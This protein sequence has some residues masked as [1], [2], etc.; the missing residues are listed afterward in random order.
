MLFFESQGNNIFSYLKKEKEIIL[1]NNL[2]N[3]LSINIKNDII[4][5][6]S[7][8]KKFNYSSYNKI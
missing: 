8:E 5:N 1:N 4:N 7:N 3:N 2:V 6:N